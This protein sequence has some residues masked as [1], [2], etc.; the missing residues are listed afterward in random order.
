MIWKLTHIS[1]ASL[2]FPALMNSVSASLNLPLKVKNYNLA[3]HHAIINNQ[4]NKL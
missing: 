3:V 1:T 4:N 2:G